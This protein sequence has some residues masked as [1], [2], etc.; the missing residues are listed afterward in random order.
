MSQ[1]PSDPVPPSCGLCFRKIQTRHKFVNCSI[2][3][4]TL[5]IGCNNIDSTYYKK[6]DKNKNITMCKICDTHMPFS[7]INTSYNKHDNLNRELLA[8]EDIK[9]LFKGINELNSNN[10][11]NDNDID[12]TPIIDCKYVDVDYFKTFKIKKNEFSIIHLNIA[13]LKK[14]KEELETLLSTIGFKFDVIGITE[15]KIKKSVEPD[16]D[17]TLEGYKQFSTPTESEKGGVMLYISDK[18]NSIP[19]KNLDSTV[20]KT[21]VLES[22]FAE[23][24]I[25]GK[26]N[27]VVGCIYRHPSMTVKDFN[28]NFWDQ[29]ME[30]L[31]DKKHNFLLGD[32]NV[33]LMKTESDEDS[34]TYL[35]TLTSNLFVPHIIYPTRITP[36][37][38]TLIDN[39]FSNL[40]NFSQGK[41]GNLTV[42][43]SDHLAQFLTIPLETGEKI[44]E[45]DFYKR[46]T[47]NF[48]RENFFLDLLSIDWD[49]VLKLELQDPNISFCEYY[50]TINNLID[51]YMPLRKMTRKEVR[52]LFKPWINKEILNSIKE[53]DN[54]KYKLTHTKDQIKKS[55]LQKKFKDLKNKILV[56]IRKSKKSYFQDFFAKNALDIKNT[57]KGIRNLINIKGK[58]KSQPKSLLV[59]NKIITEPKKVADTFNN[60]FSNIASNLQNKIHYHG[61]DF[62]KFLTEPNPV[63]FFI[64]PTNEIEIINNI[65]K[66]NN[67]KALGPNSIPTD[68]FHLIKLNVAKPLADI[69]NLSFQT[70]IYIDV[71][72]IS[73]VAP[74]FKEKGSDLDYSNY[75]PISLLSNINKIIEKIMHERLYSFLEQH[76]CIYELQFGFRAKHSTSHALIDLI[77]D[78]RNSIDNNNFS[79]GVFIDLQKAFDTVDHKIL[80]SKLGHYGIRGKANDWFRSYLTGRKQF[81]SINGSNSDLS[82]IEFGVP[83][84]SVLGPLLFL[85]YINDLHFSIK[86]S[87]TRHYADDT[88]LLI[89][90]KSLKQLKK[91]LNIDLKI[92]TSWLKANKIALNASKTE[93]LIFRNPK[94]PINYD[95]KLSLDGNRLY[96]SKY[97]KYLGVLIDPHLNWS[98]HTKILAPKLSRAAGMLAKMRHYVTPEILRNLYFGIFSSLMTYGAQIWGQYINSHIKRI[99]KLND[100]A[101]RI[102]NFAQYDENP[103]QY[104]KKSNIL[105]FQDFIKLS[106]FIYIHD[107]FNNRLPSSLLNKYEYIHTNHN[108]QTRISHASCVKLSNSNTIEYGIHSISGQACRHWNSLQ[109]TIKNLNTLP[110]NSCKEII[111]KYIID[112]Y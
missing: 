13:S 38:K 39:I 99:I 46:D 93:I 112:T 14:H 53:R 75:R 62:S 32:F 88:C 67:N 52:L 59:N 92:L 64:K 66:L 83:Q 103:S 72:K 35:D 61:K 17:T 111:R 60:Y 31:T 104:Y 102:I 45:K 2:C 109:V 85:I 25:P 84:G 55:D 33:D 106:N 43:I 8:S 101:I 3:K 73:K 11:V 12:L 110:R 76:K 37:T 26:K 74:I 44:P 82:A 19:R 10:I 16:Y 71:L 7:S 41:S 57:W 87:I 20:Y 68:I 22:V 6:L 96:P 108:H 56:D 98:Y 95:L 58:N 86:Y 40:P 21:Y 77:E 89:K 80:L 90:N 50:T 48:D 97:V 9:M 94:K 30:K 54:L 29:L 36:H 4:A 49:E 70:G 105:K 79:V 65:N 18:H 15:T 51:K 69:V 42:A 107:H 23:I 24:I 27:I 28:E 63:T 100:K 34:M 78:V 81:V 5:H 1:T 47:K 91:Q